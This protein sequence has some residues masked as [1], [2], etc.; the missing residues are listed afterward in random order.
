MLTGNQ[1]RSPFANLFATFH[2]RRRVFR[3]RHRRRRRR[4]RPACREQDRSRGGRARPTPFP[5]IPEAGGRDW[6]ATDR[7]KT[8]CTL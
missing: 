3:T 4:H 2:Q 5:V 7:G 6:P 1:I 8:I